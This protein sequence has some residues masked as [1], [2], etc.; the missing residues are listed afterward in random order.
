MNALLKIAAL[1]LLFPSAATPVLAQT[2]YF[3]NLPEGSSPQ[4]VGKR[5]AEHFVT[6][7][8]QGTGTIFYGECAAWYGALT[9][10]QL[11]HDDALRQR[12]V[13]K[14]VPSCPA[15]QRLRA[16]PFAIM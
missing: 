16:S 6:T 1:A 3:S 5:L 11:T 14:F 15:A 7:P 9:V 8:H 2:D 4:E 12:L 13:D 10:A